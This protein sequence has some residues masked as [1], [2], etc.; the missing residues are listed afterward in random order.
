MSSQNPPSLHHEWLALAE[1]DRGA[2]HDATTFPTV[3]WRIVCFHAQQ[4][5]EKFLKAFLVYHGQ[6]PQRTHDLALLLAD[7]LVLDASLTTLDPDCLTLGVYAVAPRYPGFTATL[8]E[9]EGN[10][11]LAAME[12][13]RAAV[14][15]LLPA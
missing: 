2:A 1:D 5:A 3:R 7:C 9:Q 12:R 15:A 11:A 4:A 6:M 14:L 8:G 10:D 13:I